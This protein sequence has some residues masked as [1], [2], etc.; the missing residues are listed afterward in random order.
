[1]RIKI[2]G[3]ATLLLMGGAAAAPTQA[4]DPGF[5]LCVLDQ[6]LLVR[7]SR[8]AQEMGTHFQQVRQQAQVKLEDERRTL[9]AD[10]RALDSLR[11]SLPPVVAKA[12]DA[13]IARRRVELKERGEQTN[14]NLAALDEQLTANVVK[15][16]EPVVRAVEVERGCSM[17]ID[18][19]KLL[20]VGD[21]SLDITLRVIE[22]MNAAPPSQAPS[23]R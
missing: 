2:T 15:A 20:H 23:L 4:V 12:R 18:K 6:A 22:R 9:E 8:L 7:H 11:T 19:A 5:R 17:L 14:R 3:L 21:N 1:M 16:A 10:A 13:D